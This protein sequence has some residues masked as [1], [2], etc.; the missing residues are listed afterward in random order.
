MRVFFWAVL[1]LFF[2]VAGQAQDGGDAARI[3]APGVAAPGGLDIVQEPLCF[4]VRSEAPYKVYGTFTTDYYTTPDGTKARHRSNFRLEEGGSV[5]PEKGYPTDRAEFCSYGPFLPGRMLHLT[6]RTLVPI[7][8][9]KTKIDQG[10]IVIKGYRKPEGG[11]ET[12]AEC[13]Q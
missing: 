9:C 12:W 10:E 6:L 7:F 8:S 1:F 2:P 13:Y 11:T 3:A 5:D 4:V